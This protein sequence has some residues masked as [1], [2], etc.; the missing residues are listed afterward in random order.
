LKIANCKLKSCGMTPSQVSDRLLDFSV[1]V[2]AV[3]DALPDTKLGRHVAGQ[4]V[5][6]G[7]SSF[8]NYEEGC[9]AE[10]RDDF[11]HKLSVALKEM[12]ES[13]GWLRF[14]A[15]AQLL[16]EMKLAA[17]IDEAAQLMNIL[18]K[19]VTTAKRNAPAAARSRR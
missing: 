14:I 1:R 19:S 6:C 13:H 11:I 3:V 12:R 9:A 17:L 18:G 8:P 10:S 5:R 4:L 2:G 7:T 16:R 15:R